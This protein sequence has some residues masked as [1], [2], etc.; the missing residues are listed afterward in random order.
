M[1]LPA[2][3]A[4]VQWL[5]SR[6][7]RQVSLRIDPRGGTVQVILPPRCRRTSGLALL[8]Q[9]ADWVVDRL[10][11]LPPHIALAHGSPMLL[12]GREHVIRHLPLAPPGAWLARN[13]IRV[14]GTR[15][16]LPAAVS[17]F[18]RAEALRVMSALVAAKAARLDRLPRRVLVK[19][20]ATRWGSCAADGSIAFNWR[21]I[22]APPFVQDYVA[23]HET[24]HLH[25]MNHSADFWAAVAKLT[26]HRT[27]AEEWLR[28]EGARLLR[29]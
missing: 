17:A 7:A 21:L 10:A 13:E 4:R 27:S 14:G 9:H 16:Q 2:G 25:Y 5:R 20:T 23:S 11:A 22:M 29:A 12:N 24:A 18:L 8:M 26:P 3:A 1:T 28:R 19:D 15:Q 6:R